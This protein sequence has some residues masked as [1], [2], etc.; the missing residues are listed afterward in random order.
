MEVLTHLYTIVLVQPVYNLAIAAYTSLG[1]NSLG[2]TLILIGVISA[3][4]FIPAMIRNF[5]DQEQVKALQDK[6]N[7]IKQKVTDPQEQQQQILAFLKTKGVRFQSESV[8]L[9]GQAIML[10]LLY[11]ILLNWKSANPQLLYSFITAPAQFSALFFGLDL[12]HSSPTLSL[13]PAILLFFELRLSYK[14]QQFLTGFIDKWYPVIL[15][16]FSYFLIFWLPSGLSLALAAALSVSL[17]L[18]IA[19]GVFSKARRPQP[20]SA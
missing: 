3:A 17:Y 1:Q 11:P 4:C 12:S 9:F 20:K 8:F 16:L 2:L 19:L 14:E 18:K 7:D 15:P 6:I 5:Y 13:L 10:F